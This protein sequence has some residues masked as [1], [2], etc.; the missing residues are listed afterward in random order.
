MH[1]MFAEKTTNRVHKKSSQVG[2]C[3]SVAKATRKPQQSTI[4]DFMRASFSC[5]LKMVRVNESNS[6]KILLTIMLAL[7]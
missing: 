6:S 4:S 2:F 7:Q 3:W 5:N 1:I